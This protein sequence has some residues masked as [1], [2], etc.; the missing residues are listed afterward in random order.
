MVQRDPGKVHVH[1]HTKGKAVKDMVKGS[2]RV[3][4][5]SCPSSCLVEAAPT[6]I[7]M[8]DVSVSTIKLEGAPKHLMEESVKRMALV[9]LQGLFCS[10]P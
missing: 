6:W 1:N 5:A 3:A 2:G 7:C 8:A 4:R 10:S 9:L